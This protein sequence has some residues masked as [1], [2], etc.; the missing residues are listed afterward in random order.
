MVCEQTGTFESI[1]LNNG[2]TSIPE[3]QQRDKNIV[4]SE[5]SNRN[6]PGEASHEHETSTISKYITH[7]S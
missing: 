7:S 4:K 5:G 1:L 2:V 6:C 3:Q